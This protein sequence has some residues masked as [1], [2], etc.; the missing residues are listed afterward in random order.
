MG[1]GTFLM[2]AIM[3]ICSS[4]SHFSTWPRAL[5]VEMVSWSG[6]TS[7]SELFMA[8]MSSVS[9]NSRLAMPSKHFF[10]CGCTLQDRSD[11]TS[12]DPTKQFIVFVEQQQQQQEQQEFTCARLGGQGKA[13]PKLR[14]RHE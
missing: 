14:S 3:P 7:P 8:T 9:V 1:V 6:T 2:L 11:K 12:R 4:S 13:E 10:K 5:A